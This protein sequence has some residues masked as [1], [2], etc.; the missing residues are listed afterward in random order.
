MEL[1]INCV[2]KKRRNFSRIVLGVGLFCIFLMPFQTVAQVDPLEEIYQSRNDL[3]AIFDPTTHRAIQ[4]SSGLMLDLTDWARRYGWQEYG[5]LQSYGPQPNTSLPVRIHAKEIESKIGAYAYVVM[6]RAS[7]EML[8]VKRENRQW[9]IASLTKLVTSSVVVDQGIPMTKMADIQTIDNV[10]GAQLLVNDGDTMTV[11]DLFYATLVASANNAA[12]A[13]ARTTGLSKTA[14]VK[15]MN[16]YAQTLNLSHTSFVD[17]TGIEVHNL[18]TP[19]EMAR[20]AL[21]AF[22]RE[23]IRDSVATSSK[24]IKVANTGATK[25]MINTNWMLWKPQYD[26]VWVTGGKTGYLDESG[27]NL[28]VSLKSTQQDPREL[29]IVIFG[30]SSRASSFADAD[31]LS[32]WAWDVYE[33]KKPSST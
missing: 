8:T 21:D 1:T 10:G 27:W 24:L 16:T 22:S 11:R 13:L 12:N 6:D 17:P 26:D 4:G 23:E 7:G 20:I 19:L 31:A 28:V 33:W 30:A 14:F 2:Q 3:Q 15:A 25:N 32:L 9:P 29:L 5:V 18:S